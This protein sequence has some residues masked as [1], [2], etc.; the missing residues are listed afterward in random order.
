MSAL[1]KKDYKVILD[2]YGVQNDKLKMQDLRN[3]AL[4]ILANK[5]CRCIKKINTDT[6]AAV[7]ICKDSVFGKKDLV[8]SRFKCKDTPKLIPKKGKKYA[9]TKKSKRKGGGIGS[10]KPTVPQIKESVNKTRKTISF[11]PSTKA[12]ISP[13]QNKKKQMFI[14][15]NK[16]RQTAV[17]LYENRQ[18]QQDLR[19]MILGKIPLKGGN[20]NK[21]IKRRS[22][23]KRKTRKSNC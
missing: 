10:S 11:S 8:V 17:T 2:Y 5:L 21:T 14:S 7:P 18:T 22:S 1:T 16:H 3:T 19:D 13:K 23:N 6:N 20:K 15:K 4:D 9:V 12:P